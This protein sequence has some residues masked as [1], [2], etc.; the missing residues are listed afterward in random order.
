MQPFA[1]TTSGHQATGKFIHDNDFAIFDNV[2]DI[3]SEERMR[4]ESLVDV[5]QKFNIAGIE[6]IV[7]L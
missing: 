4:L 7:D 6:D 3:S 5:V 2:V 1:V